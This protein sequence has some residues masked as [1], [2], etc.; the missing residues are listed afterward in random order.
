MLA[1]LLRPAVRAAPPP[2]RLAFARASS[3]ASPFSSDKFGAR[4]SPMAELV[5]ASGE[6]DN[7]L[8]QITKA[9]DEAAELLPQGKPVD[10]K[11]GELT[12]EAHVRETGTKFGKARL[13]P[14]PLPFLLLTS[15]QLIQAHEWSQKFALAQSQTRRSRKPIAPGS[16]EARYKDVFRQLGIDPVRECKNVPLMSWYTSDMGKA[17][18]R[19][20][21]NLSWRSQRL[22]GRALR[23]AK[24]M[25]VLPIL[26]KGRRARDVQWKQ[27]SHFFLVGTRAP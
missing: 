13:P 6:S 8:D 18:P 5:D 26:S 23:R 22:V 10:L 27:V 12:R 21:T 20:E 15:L 19:S 3:S 7:H 11:A 25:G 16:A 9:L 1:N 14:L 24:M 4:R 17:K 2:A